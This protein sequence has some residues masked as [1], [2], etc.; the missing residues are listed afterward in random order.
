MR[1]GKGQTKSLPEPGKADISLVTRSVIYANIRLTV[2]PDY[3][4]AVVG[5][6]A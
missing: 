6:A 1:S 4:S 2:C 3:F 5:R